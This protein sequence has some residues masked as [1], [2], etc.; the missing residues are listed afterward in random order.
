[1]RLSQDQSR[2]YARQL[3]LDEVGAEG[4]RRLLE[5]TVALHGEG[6]AVEEAA[7]YLA[8][9]GVGRVILSPPLAE[10]LR[11]KLEALNPDVSVLLEGTATVTIASIEP[12]S[13]LAGSA[14]ALTT[15]VGLTGAATP[16]SFPGVEA[17]IQW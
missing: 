6:H 11:P 10:V 3:F 12:A 1:M 4:Q 9:A 16:P 8:A 13:R 2:R 7:T 15:L 5:A 14:V 17:V